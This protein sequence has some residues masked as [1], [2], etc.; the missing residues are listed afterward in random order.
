[1]QCIQADP[2]NRPESATAVLKMLK[3]ASG[4]TN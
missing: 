2:N 4:D 3:Q 1:M